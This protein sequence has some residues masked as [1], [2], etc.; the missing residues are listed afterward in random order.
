MRIRVTIDVTKPL[1]RKKKLNIILPKPVWVKFKN[2]CMSDFCFCYRVLGHDHKECSKWMEAPKFYEKAKTNIRQL[3]QPMLDPTRHMPSQQGIRAATFNPNESNLYNLHKNGKATNTG[4]AN[5]REN[6][7][8]T[9]ADLRVVGQSQDPN[10]ERDLVFVEAN[11][12]ATLTTNGS[13][14]P[15]EGARPSPPKIADV[16]TSLVSLAPD[17]TISL[18]LTTSPNKTTH[19]SP[20]KL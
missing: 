20:K 5:R 6:L 4:S 14:N 7:I 12:K 13:N 16:A 17:P 19:K 15:Q 2:K 18:R 1:L 3:L 9:Q 8:S 10:E 11:H